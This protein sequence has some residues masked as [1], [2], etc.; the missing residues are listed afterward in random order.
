MYDQTIQYVQRGVS[1]Y[2]QA[3]LETCNN[4]YIYIVLN[5]P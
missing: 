3:R 2:T 5:V 4:I 1:D